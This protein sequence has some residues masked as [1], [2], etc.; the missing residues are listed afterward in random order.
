MSVYFFLDDFERLVFFC[1]RDFFVVFFF[2]EPPFLKNCLLVR[3]S[4]FPKLKGWAVWVVWGGA[5]G[6]APIDG[7]GSFL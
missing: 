3:V 6:G 5:G 1:L 2:F 4:K 7:T